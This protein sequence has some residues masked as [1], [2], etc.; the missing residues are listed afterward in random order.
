MTGLSKSMCALACALTVPLCLSTAANAESTLTTKTEK[1]IVFK[2][3]FCMIVKSATATADAN[4]EVHLDKVPD[5]AILGSFWARSENGRLISMTAGWRKAKIKTSKDELCQDRLEILLANKG[6]DCNIK[7][8]KDQFLSG[9]IHEVLATKK[10][11]N[12]AT[13]SR[14][15]RPQPSPDNTVL[16]EQITGDSF[17][18]RAKDGDHLLRISQIQQLTIKDMKTT[19]T[20][21]VHESKKHKRLTLKFDTPGKAQKIHIV[22]FRPGIRWVPTYRVNL[23]NTN[24]KQEA[25]LNLQAEILN[26]AEDLKN[27]PIDIVVGVPNF[28]FKNAVSPL[29]LEATLRRTLV[30]AAPQL[31][32][33]AQQFSNAAYGQRS[34]EFRRDAAGS[35]SGG[36]SELPKELSGKGNQDLFIYKLPPITLAKSQRCAVPIFTAKVP[37]KDVYTWDIQLKGTKTRNNQGSPLALSKN[38]VW[39]QIELENTLKMPW[40]TGAAMLMSGQQPLAQELLTYTSPGDSVRI[41]VTVAVD[42]RGFT[43]FWEDSRED[44]KTKWNG[45]YYVQLKN[46]ARVEVCNHKNSTIKIEINLSVGGKATAASDSGAIKLLPYDARDWAD[47]RRQTMLNNSS[48]VQWKLDLK[49]GQVFKPTIDFQYFTRS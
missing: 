32:N 31:M 38:K 5:S 9:K 15:F 44:K 36:A 4:G 14:S 23:L 27:V 26:E 37:Y 1:V 19:I 48:R 47:Y 49:P 18:L 16:H 8:G 21:T 2:D 3:G 20:K 28:R 30:Q 43:K 25:E 46:K 17:I 39:H 34:S 33:R 22:Y 7:L 24:G 10:K 35:S 41:P 12:P 13:I 11:V 40:T 42:V 29:I 45:Y 6:R